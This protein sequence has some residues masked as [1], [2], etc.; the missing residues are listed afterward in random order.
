MGSIIEINYGTIIA[1]VLNFVLLVGIIILIYKLMKALRNIKL[2]NK[3][4][5]EKIHFIYN[6]LKD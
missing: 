4:M 3:E 2:R 5:D 6:K 1:T